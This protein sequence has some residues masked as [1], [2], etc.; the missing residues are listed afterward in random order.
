MKEYQR[1]T[2]RREAPL[3]MSQ[4]SGDG[5]SLK[6]YNRLADLE[7]KIESGELV[8]RNEYLDYLM[9]AQDTSADKENNDVRENAEG[10]EK[11]LRE[12]IGHLAKDKREEKELKKELDDLRRWKA[13]SMELKARVHDRVYIPTWYKGDYVIRNEEVLG[14]EVP[15]TGEV[16]YRVTTRDRK[17][18]PDDP[19]RNEQPSSYLESQFGKCIFVDSLAAMSWVIEKRREEG[20]DGRE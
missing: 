15:Y 6:I 10:R 14:I 19:Y 11:R 1:L 2:T 8:A 12:I 9:D 4:W 13:H 5:Q 20:I 16:W 18:I 17:A 7:D 3:V